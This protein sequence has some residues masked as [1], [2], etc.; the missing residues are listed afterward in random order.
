[1]QSNRG[2]SKRTEDRDSNPKNTAELHVRGSIVAGFKA[3]SKL[4]VSS[5]QQ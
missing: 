1:M 2:Q 4:N 5:G 3:A